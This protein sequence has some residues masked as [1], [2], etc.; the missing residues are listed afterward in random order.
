MFGAGNNLNSANLV[1]K[2]Q[3]MR[4]GVFSPSY[5]PL[6]GGA[7][8]FE[9]GILH[10]LLQLAPES[11]HQFT[12][13]LSNKGRDD[14]VL[15]RGGNVE[16]VYLEPQPQNLFYLLAQRRQS[17]L[18]LSRLSKIMDF[19]RMKKVEHPLQTALHNHKVD[20][21]WFV[22]PYD[23][24]PL[25]IPY[26]ATVWDIQHR[27]QPWFPEVSNNGV[28]EAREAAYSVFLRR[29]LFVLTPNKVAGDELSLFYQIPRDRL[30]FLPHPT[31]LVDQLP[32]TEQVG[33]ALAKY[34]LHSHY[35]L[36]PAQFWPH[37]NHINLLLAL[38]VLRDTYGLDFHLVLAGADHGNQKYVEQKTLQMGLG[39]F[40]HFLGFVPRED[41]LALYL[42]A[43]ALSYV[44]YFGPENLPPLEA[45]YLG[46]PVVV[47]K[48][49]GALEQLGDAALFVNG[50]Q[51]EEIAAA[52]KR[53][54][55]D[56]ELRN[57]LITKGRERAL[58]YTNHDYVRDVLGL[59]AEFE[60]V[61]R[62]WE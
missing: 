47:S 18:F 26:L 44:T 43:F 3:V 58:H 38:R 41:L 16:V 24:F 22:T 40:V 8:T 32:T 19:L 50:S 10:A 52:V 34:G 4:I 29:A 30:R 42:G 45:F 1:K 11:R 13:F 62:N 48:F 6:S 55:D 28:W 23:I 17:S 36:Y 53:L 59:A 33:T 61:R 7:H 49:S 35:L 5:T 57:A 56:P 20:L 21:F 2:T 37:K 25:N 12:L 15:S 14:V 51:P 27:L 54:Y 31:P 46:C 9:Q 60:S 39:D